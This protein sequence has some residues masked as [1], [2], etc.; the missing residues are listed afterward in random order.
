MVL[1]LWIE[2]GERMRVRIT[3]TVDPGAEDPV[4]TYASTKA[5]VVEVVEDWLDSVVTPR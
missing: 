2:A 1:H 4:T 3:R 5:Q